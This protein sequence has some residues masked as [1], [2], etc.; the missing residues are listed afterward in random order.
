MPIERYDGLEVGG[1]RD[2]CIVMILEIFYEQWTFQ[3][4]TFCS[5]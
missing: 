3:N 1:F 5:T 4:V 2:L